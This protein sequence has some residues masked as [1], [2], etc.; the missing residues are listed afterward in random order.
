MAGAGVVV[1]HPVTGAV[2][3][4]G[5]TGV[6]GIYNVELPEGY[7][8]ITVTE[9]HHSSVTGNVLV[10]PGTTNYQEIFLSYTAITYSWD[11]VETEVE[12]EY[13][14]ETVAKYETNVPK[15][16][17]VVNL[18]SERPA[19]GSVIAILVT[20]KGLINA[21][22][23]VMNLDCT[24][25]YELELLNPDPVDILSPQQ[26]YVFYAR[27]K[28]N[29]A[30]H[31]RRRV[32]GN[33]DVDCISIFAGA[34]YDYICGNAKNMEEALAQNGW[35]DCIGDGGNGGSTT[36]WYWRPVPYT[37]PSW[38]S[39]PVPDNCSGCTTGP[40]SNG[41]GLLEQLRQWYCSQPCGKELTQAL[42]C[43]AAG[44][45]IP[46]WISCPYDL[47]NG[48]VSRGRSWSNCIKA[49]LTCTPAGGHADC[50][51]PYI[52]CMATRNNN[53]RASKVETSIVNTGEAIAN[54]YLT[55]YTLL[56]KEKE[57]FWSIVEEHFGDKEWLDY[58]N[59][60]LVRMLDVVD[61]LGEEH[62]Y[63]SD[64]FK[65][66]KP[67]L[68]SDELLARFVE[69]LNNTFQNTDYEGITNYIHYEVM[70]NNLNVINECEEKAVTSGWIGVA[71]M[72]IDSY[73]A[74]KGY[75]SES[76]SSVCA[77]VSIKISQTMVMTRQA[78]RGTLTVF[79]GHDD[80]AMTDIKLNLVVTDANGRQATSH[81]FQVNA[82][83]LDGFI[84]ELDLG[85]GWTL[86]ANATGTAT[87]LFI[88][89][90]YAAPDT[91]M[92]WSFGGTLSYLDPFTGLEVTREL[93]PVTLTVKPCPELDM[94]Y[95][96]Q[97]DVYGDDPLTTEVEPMAP[98]E[99]ALL[100]N[101][102]GNGDA[103]NVRMVTQQPEIIENEKGLLID[104]SLLNGKEANLSF[105]QSI[106]NN[107]GNIPAHSQAYAQWWLQSSLLGHFTDYKVEANHITSY[108]NEDLSLLD[109]VT[110]HELIHGFTADVGSDVPVRGFL[111][112]DIV[113]AEDMPDQVYFTDAT[114]QNVTLVADLDISKQSDA[115][116]LL[117]AYTAQNGWNYG[118]LFDPT[119]GKQKLVS[120][121]RQSDG[122]VL[123]VDNIWQTDRTLRDGKD[124]LYENRLHFV[125]ELSGGSE[126]YLLTFERKPA[127]EL[128]VDSYT[129][130]PKENT[131]L[132]EQ[133]T[134]VTVR[135]NKP[136]V[137]STFT[138]EDITLNCQGEKL[139]VDKVE[140]VKVTDMEY[141]LGLSDV[142]LADGYYVLTV[143]TAAISDTEGF[144]GSVGKQATW[145]QFIDGKVELTVSATPAVGGTVT[146]S[147]GRYDYDSDIKLKAV[148]AE[149]YD[150]VGW[151]EFGETVSTDAEFIHHLTG[152]TSLTAQFAIKHYRVTIDYDVTLGSVEGA[153]SG[154]YDYGT[155]LELTAIPAT[156]HELDVWN[157]N[158]ENMGNDNPYV[159]LVNGVMTIEALFK[160][161]TIT[162]DLASVGDEPLRITIS[163]LPVS[164]WMCLSGNF[165]EI[166]HIDVF[167][168]SGVKRMSKSQV[169]AGERIYTGQLVSG[170][171]FVVIST[172]RGVYRTKVIKR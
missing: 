35:G 128:A 168:V 2:V 155:Q 43:E 77:S 12:D 148:P 94:T 140:I 42:A 169:Q 36:P 38:P 27:F 54:N 104:F 60:D 28:K 57:A 59:E 130:V 132:K 122:K 67:L 149:G 62:L 3:A 16:V 110:I 19:D 4:Q 159:V 10:D 166:R 58:D 135:F 160:S 64:D 70:T 115:E 127:V 118:S 69:R 137:E 23:V 5:K 105:G 52:Y 81:E 157:V 119:N 117:T 73:N 88:P 152:N 131:V 30:A 80:T 100:I 32:W 11:V 139:D 40:T 91:P 79:N 87:V 24:D 129:G 109:E 124:W 121:I 65:S 144:V 84:G 68:A 53:N 170:I 167:D 146:P 161:T 63:T 114:Q 76:A 29:S 95:F 9:G 37:G 1:R 125:G 98:A 156:G 141:R 107:F 72:Y 99:F 163:P 171:Y 48:C 136:I 49:G 55:S 89:T 25:G 14:I 41:P 17:V 154:I 93:Y 120:V 92:E 22:N 123:P 103:T 106:A 75:I 46:D 102:K 7:Y 31:S 85:S 138:P 33:P 20:N 112:N 113:D 45:V 39:G 66:V 133:L 172:E 15:P 51:L 158:G 162:T 47:L 61:A 86:E 96:M 108:G 82:E 142:T 151:T 90:K 145:I 74:V 150:F 21:Q 116:Y 56:E 6:D 134:E 13:K 97:R 8:S 165:R 50:W 126:S 71:E 153:A 111:V 26:T 44:A 78:F 18:P 34:L 143:Q 101:N 164:D 147:G 83:A